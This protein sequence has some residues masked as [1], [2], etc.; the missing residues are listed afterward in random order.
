MLWKETNK[1]GENHIILQMQNEK[2]FEDRAENGGEEGNKGKKQLV[3]I[4]MRRTSRATP[5][6]DCGAGMAR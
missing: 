1:Q 6:R 3:I 4:M 5:S 2:E